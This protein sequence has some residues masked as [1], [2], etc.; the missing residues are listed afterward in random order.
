[1]TIHVG[2]VALLAWRTERGVPGLGL[3]AMTVGAGIAA[4][5]VIGATMVSTGVPPAAQ[6][7]HVAGAAALWTAVVALA[8]LAFRP[9]LPT[10]PME[11]TT[12]WM[13][14]PGLPPVATRPRRPSAVEVIA[15]LQARG[16]RLGHAYKLHVTPSAMAAVPAAL[17]QTTARLRRA[18]GEVY[19]ELV[20]GESPARALACDEGGGACV[21]HRHLRL[22][23]RPLAAR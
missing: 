2:L 12:A 19:V 1:M 22:R 20:A 15:A 8:G 9:P 21:H 4:Q 14:G 3:A 10:G 17:F 16:E 7:L 6:V 5:I 13:P 18:E 23:V 11:L